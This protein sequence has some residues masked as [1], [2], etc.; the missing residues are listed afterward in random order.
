MRRLLSS[1]LLALAVSTNA[2]AGDYSGTDKG[3]VVIGIG[4]IGNKLD[5]YAV[6]YRV[7]GQNSSGLFGDA[8]FRFQPDALFS[9]KPDFVGKDAMHETGEVQIVHLRP[10]NYEIF[11]VDL[12]SS[13]GFTNAWL[14]SKEFSIPFV[15]RT[16]ETTYIGDYSGV[17]TPLG[18]GRMNGYFVLSDQHDR[19]IPIAKTKEHD[20]MPVTVSVPDPAVLG[21]PVIRSKANF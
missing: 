8:R 14:T 9:P 7:A 17:G 21:I 10:G 19:D 3:T 13:N 1:L 12:S 4:A 6:Y 5:G 18:Y 20:L 2:H 16:G 15:V 11:K